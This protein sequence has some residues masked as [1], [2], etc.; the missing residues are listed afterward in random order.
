MPEASVHRN[1]RQPST[2]SANPATTS[3]SPLSA[4]AAED[5]P[6]GRAPRATMP[7]KVGASHSPRRRWRRQRP[8]DHPEAILT[9]ER[10]EKLN[11]LT[12]PMWK[13]LGEVFEELSASDAVRCIIIRGDIGDEDFCRQAVEQTVKK[14]GKIDILVNNA[15]VQF[16]HR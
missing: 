12:R 4:S 11:A 1:A 15:A 2:E 7:S 8:G 3:P 14:F 9:L 13:R 6:P 5:P 16:P 10:P